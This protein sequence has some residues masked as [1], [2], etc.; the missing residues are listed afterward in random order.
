[1]A[2]RTWTE[3]ITVDAPAETVWR[4]MLDVATWPTWT[5]SMTSVTVLEPGP[6][7]VGSTVR[8][9]Q[10][11]LPAT[12]WTIDALVPG[13]SFSWRSR[14]PGVRT[15]AE[16]V[17]EP[18]APGCTVTLVVRQSG[19]LAGVSARLFG[20]L[21]RRYMRMEAEGLRRESESRGS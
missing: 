6:L 9:R 1:M 8:I 12:V 3:R 18:D 19:P 21:V 17:I 13:R 16:H 7:R 20:G 14:R 11:R 10:P 15:V 4:V 5:A 2:E